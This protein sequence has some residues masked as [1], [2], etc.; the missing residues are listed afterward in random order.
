MDT[1][2]PSQV[3]GKINHCT[4]IFYFYV[5]FQQ[6]AP[7]TLV[8]GDSRFFFLPFPSY[9]VQ[10]YWKIFFAVYFLGLLALPDYGHVNILQKTFLRTKGQFILQSE[11]LNQAPIIS[12]VLFLYPELESKI[13]ENRIL[14]LV[15]IVFLYGI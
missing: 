2:V 4:S 7:L 15:L 13:L 3:E 8:K 10:S 9:V 1:P 12:L 5:I 14:Y 6:H 11:A